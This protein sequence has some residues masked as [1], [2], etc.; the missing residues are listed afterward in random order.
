MTMEYQGIYVPS[1][2]LPL[3]LDGD[4]N[5]DVAFV[6]KTSWQVNTYQV[7]LGSKYV[8][9]GNTYGRLIYKANTT[10]S[11]QRIWD[12]RMYLYPVPYDDFVVNPALGQNPGWEM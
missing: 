5:E 1:T 7:M 11:V 2:D 12:D 4:G 6:K 10:E 9:S 3:D 8:L